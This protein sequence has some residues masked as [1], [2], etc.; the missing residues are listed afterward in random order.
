M[1]PR[2]AR[3]APWL[4]ALCLAAQTVHAQSLTPEQLEALVDERV[5]AQNPF[6]E[7]LNDPDP[8]RSLAAMEIMLESGDPD[9]VRMALEFGLLST[10]PTVKRTAVEAFLKTRPVL[11]LRFDGSAIEEDRYFKTRMTG[12]DATLTTEGVGYWRM[13]VGEWNPDNRCYMLMSG[14]DCFVTVNSDGIILQNEGY[15]TGRLVIGDAGSLEGSATLYQVSTP[16]P[17]TVRLLD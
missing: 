12:K 14:K 16:V 5:A 1:V 11:S 10:N 4:A 7:L 2:S 6:E 9:L 3:V 15:M 13:Q 17:V 8:A